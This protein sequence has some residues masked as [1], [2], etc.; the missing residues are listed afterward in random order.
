MAPDLTYPSPGQSL[1]GDGCRRRENGIDLE[2][3]AANRPG[4]PAML[5]ASL[6]TRVPVPGPQQPVM[7]PPVFLSDSRASSR[8]LPA[9]ARKYYHIDCFVISS[10]GLLTIG[11]SYTIVCLVFSF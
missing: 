11:I 2:S 9:K 1:L 6:Y 7:A 8:S 10:R 4:G 5:A 3:T